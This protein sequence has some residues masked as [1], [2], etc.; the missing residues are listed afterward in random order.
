MADLRPNAHRHQDPYR[1]RP[2]GDSIG[3]ENR[4]GEPSQRGQ[5]AA[6]H[7]EAVIAG[8]AQQHSESKKQQG[9]GQQDA[10]RRRGSVARH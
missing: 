7:G 2:V 8:D 3:D 1:Q 5:E 6:R 4:E 10:F 9:G